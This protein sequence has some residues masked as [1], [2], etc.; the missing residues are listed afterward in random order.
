MTAAIITARGGSTRIPRKNVAY[1][2]GLPLLAWSIIQAQNSRLVDD[3]FLTTDDSEMAE[4][5]KAFGATV[6][7]RPVWDNGVTAGQAFLN[8]IRKIEDDGKTYGT[9]VPMVP[10]ACLR[11]PDHVDR[12]IAAHRATGRMV[13]TACP[14][15]EMFIFR[16]EKPFHN[17]FKTNAVD[18]FYY[19]KQVTG[20]KFWSFSE[21]LGGDS[22]D[23][24]EKMVANWMRTPEMDIDNDIAPID[25]SKQWCFIPVEPWQTIDIDYQEDL[26]LVRLV[27]EHYIMSRGGVR[28]YETYSE[29][30]SAV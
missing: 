15:K 2:C 20:D 30:G 22:C 26:D 17:R 19:A 23:S 21:L 14:R 12:L 24:C 18:N 9:I 1:V 28:W 7:R 4:I 25:T 16:N 11:K 27:F 5:G 29:G 10:T 8:C 3:V 6:Y 13:T